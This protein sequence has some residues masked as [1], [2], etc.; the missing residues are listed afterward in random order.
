VFGPDVDSQ[1]D[2]KKYSDLKKSW[3]ELHRMDG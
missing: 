2:G 1:A 3:V